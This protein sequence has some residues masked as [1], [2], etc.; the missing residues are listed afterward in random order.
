MESWFQFKLSEK[1]VEQARENLKI[2]GDHN[3]SGLVGLSDLL[4]AKAMLQQ[5]TDN[6]TD[7]R[8]TYQIRKANH[9]QSIGD[10]HEY[11]RGYPEREKTFLHKGSLQP[12]I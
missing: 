12:L 4:E 2:T 8:C 10:Y 11:R 6:L 1:S 3:H 9:L 7:A 5:A